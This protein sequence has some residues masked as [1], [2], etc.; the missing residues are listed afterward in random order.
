LGSV[1]A[2]R[3]K[4]PGEVKVWDAGSGQEVLALKGHLDSVHDLAYSPD[5]QRLA[6]AG[7][8]R[9]VKVWDAQNGRELLSLKVDVAGFRSVAYS[10]DGQRLASAGHDQAVKVWDAET[11]REV[12]TLKGHHGAVRGVAFSPNGHYLASAGQDKTVKV[13]EIKT[14]REAFTLKGHTS[15]VSRVAYSPDGQFLA[16]ASLDG[17]VKVWD[18]QTGQDALDLNGHTNTVTSVAFSPDGKRLASAAHAR[19]FL[20]PDG[21]L[22]SNAAHDPTVKVWD[23]RT[24]QELLSLKGHPGDVTS[25]AF[26]PDGKRLAGA[27]GERGKP[28]EVKVW[29]AGTGQELLSLKGHPGDV[30][31]VAFSPDGKRLASASWNKTVKVW[32]AFSGQEILSLQGHACVAFSP[33]GKRLASVGVH[34][35]GAKP[36]GWQVKVWDAGN[37]QEVL[38]LKGDTKS[39]FIGGNTVAFSSDGKRLASTNGYEVKVWDAETGQESLTLKGH[40]QPVASV[41][42]SP[43]SQRLA[44]ASGDGTVKVWDTAT[45][46]E[47]L[48]F[49]IGGNVHTVAFSP[50]GQRLASDWYHLVRVWDARVLTEDEKAAAVLVRALFAEG[51]T[52]AEVLAKIGKDP[53]LP[54]VIRR[55]AVATAQ[56]YYLGPEATAEALARR[57]QAHAL[58]KDWAQAVAVLSKAISMRP[59]VAEYWRQRADVHTNQKLWTHVTADLS[60][61]LRLS[62]NT[63]WYWSRRAH[64]HC[65]QYLWDKAASDFEKAIS[66][67][68]SEANN[69]MNRADDLRCLAI[70][71]LVS[72][73]AAGYCRECARLLPLLDKLPQ[74]GFFVYTLA[75][76]SGAVPDMGQVVRLAETRQKVPALADPVRQ[77]QIKRNLGVILYRAG[78]YE[79]AI[80]HMKDGKPENDWYYC[81]FQAM[82]Y[83]RLGKTDE[84]KTWLEKSRPNLRR[85]EDLS[86]RWRE[87]LRLLHHEAQ[88]LIQSKVKDAKP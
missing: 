30:R 28:P 8:D 83:Q 45:G 57:A 72:G 77:D 61:A 26:S 50:D 10:P 3:R 6:T 44:S 16:S 13:W 4:V 2:Q 85:M 38:S 32:D 81:P 62:P 75:V 15:L 31:S 56:D 52:P 46:Q 49:R 12:L 43:D 35:A 29:D 9:L 88:T 7:G 64:A 20:S 65:E 66:L 5:G 34:E 68:A 74:A 39:G 27:V 18:A 54:E 78:K 79:Q 73:D 71:R 41:A 1:D 82:A 51:L 76:A 86:W 22:R 36:H 69:L 70:V 63:Y 80:Q 59:S 60:E 21:K 25:L 37:G 33:D 11:G 87:T 67:N 14:G 40:T 47:T 42:Y 23:V 53:A 58:R 24:G 48:T 84:A 55:F 19:V 17:T